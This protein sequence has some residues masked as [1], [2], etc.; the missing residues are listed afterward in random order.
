MPTEDF[1]RGPVDPVVVKLVR[2][3]KAPT[4]RKL[5]PF[6]KM[7]LFYIYF[8]PSATLL[9]PLYILRSLLPL[10][11]LDP[12]WSFIQNL[13]VMHV[14]RVV[15][16]FTRFGVQPIQPRENGWRESSTI[17]GTFLGLLNLSGPG[18]RVVH[19]EMALRAAEHAAG[20][21]A[22]RVW[23][24]PPP[25]D[26]FRGLLTIRTGKAGEG[27]AHGPTYNGPPLIDPAFA[28]VRTRCFWFMH[29]DGISPPVPSQ[30]G[31]TR[32]SDRPVILYFHGGASVTFSAGDLF[33][34]ET[35]AKNLAHTT[36]ID[37]FSVDYLLAPEATFPGSIVQ[38]LASWFYLTRHLG[39]LPSQII[40]GGDSYGG[41]LVLSLT[42]YLL[43]DFRLYEPESGAEKPAALLLLSPFCDA[44][45]SIEN[46]PECFDENSKK[47]II[48]LPYGA[49]GHEARGLFGD[50]SADR[51][52]LK[53]EDPWFTFANLPDEEAKRYPPMFIANGRSELLW[54]MG[55]AMVERCRSLGLNVYHHVDPYAVHDYFTL[56]IFL[57]EAKVTYQAFTKWFREGVQRTQSHL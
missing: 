36:G 40:L 48:A 9:T 13:G 37:V 34:G 20:Q 6:L 24:P 7:L 54:D 35:L 38:A 44:R 30:K 22:D 47:D 52:F 42:R 33:M 32:N 11:R 21:R 26:A 49:W 15:R 10:T 4:P 29:K 57:E 1:A 18:G 19:P 14:R 53:K 56:V 27:T 28:K 43:G 51:G 5:I 46:K 31:R 17:L 45:A 25:L 41:E 16:L 50:D 39:Y 23:I 3:A 12:R 8:V 55:V 2:Q